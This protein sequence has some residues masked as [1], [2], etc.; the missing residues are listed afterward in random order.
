MQTEGMR[1]ESEINDKIQIRNCKIRP[2]NA[3]IDKQKQIILEILTQI[4]RKICIKPNWRRSKSEMR[5]RRKKIGE[6]IATKEEEDWSSQKLYLSKNQL[7]VW[8]VV[9]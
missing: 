4:N 1:Y 9:C 5:R 8:L 2:N 3:E 7:T 6:F